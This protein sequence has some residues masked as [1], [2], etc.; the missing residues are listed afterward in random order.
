M[1]I[2]D[3]FKAVLRKFNHQ[4]GEGFTTI[5]LPTRGEGV[6]LHDGL[7]I[8][9][10]RPGCVPFETY[11]Q[12]HYPQHAAENIA[13][14]SVHEAAL[15]DRGVARAYYASSDDDEFSFSAGTTHDD[16]VFSAFDNNG[17]V[18]GLGMGFDS[19]IAMSHGVNPATGLPMISDSVD[20]GGNVFGT[21]SF[22]SMGSSFDGGFGG[23]SGGSDF[24][25][26]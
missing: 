19:D 21:S 2:L 4:P 18:G 3:S 16:G 8:A 6:V 11:A 12:E 20:A 22:D 26:F 10:N 1:S 17:L 13:G 15:G 25:S 24:S 5:V 7:G 9:A 14:E 23:C